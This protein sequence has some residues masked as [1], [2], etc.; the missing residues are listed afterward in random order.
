M[1]AHR[2][3]MGMFC[4]TGQVL[5]MHTIRRFGALGFATIMTSRQFVSVL[6]SCLIF[7]HPLSL[8]QW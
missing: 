8:G 4:C 1:A 5:I 7:A 3:M 6:A 2:E